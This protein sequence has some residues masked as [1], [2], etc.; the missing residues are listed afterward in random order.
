M[1]EQLPCVLNTQQHLARVCRSYSCSP[2]CPPA[3]RALPRCPSSPF[4]SIWNEP[5]PARTTLAVKKKKKNKETVAICS[6]PACCNPR[7]SQRAVGPL[8]PARPAHRP[9]PP[10]AHLS[11]FTCTGPLTLLSSRCTYHHPLP[12]CHFAIPTALRET[13]PVAF[14]LHPPVSS[15]PPPPLCTLPGH[16]QRHVQERK[17]KKG[18][19][20]QL[21][22]QS[23][24]R[25]EC[26]NNP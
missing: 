26:G 5:V 1:S 10:A 13:H 9:A 7:P 12:P 14:I 8:G 25:R 24:V 6:L 20:S 19:I 11:V 15:S 22:D 16:D 17:K 18:P 3:L 23:K 21:L 4:E 2:G